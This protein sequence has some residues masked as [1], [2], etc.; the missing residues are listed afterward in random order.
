[1]KIDEIAMQNVLRVYGKQIKKNS[2]LKNRENPEN[3]D[4]S[5]DLEKILKE[6]LDLINYDKN[7]NIKLNPDK[8]K[9]LVDFFE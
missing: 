3:I 8:K 7:G 4:K 2:A 6:D 1:M 5:E 9:A